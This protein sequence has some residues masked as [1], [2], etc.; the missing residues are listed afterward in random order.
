MPDKKLLKGSNRPGGH[1]PAGSPPEPV[2]NPKVTCFPHP[3]LDDSARHDQNWFMRPLSVIKQRSPGIAI[4]ENTPHGLK[5]NS[6]QRAQNSITEMID[7]TAIHDLAISHG[8]DHSGSEFLG[9]RYHRHSIGGPDQMLQD[10]T[11]MASATSSGYMHD[12]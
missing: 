3:S 4:L 2:I 6:S 8:S 1:R 7:L 9:P 12:T 5:D 11:L 10:F